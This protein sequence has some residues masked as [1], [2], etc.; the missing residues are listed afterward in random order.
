MKTNILEREGIVSQHPQ[1]HYGI[2]V[3]LD[4]DVK[5]K[6]RSLSPVDD[7]SH[8]IRPAVFDTLLLRRQELQAVGFNI[9]LEQI[10]RQIHRNMRDGLFTDDVFFTHVSQLIATG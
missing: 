2:I 3:I 6:R 5:D 4:F 10:G 8:Q 7:S 9:Q 1:W